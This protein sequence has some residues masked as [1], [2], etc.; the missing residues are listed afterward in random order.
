[1]PAFTVTAVIGNL[2]A[3]MERLRKMRRKIGPTVKKATTKGA[4]VLSKGQKVRAKESQESGL[5]WKSLGYVVRVYSGDGRVIAAV[6]PRTGMGATV[7]LLDGK[8]AIASS[9]AGQRLVAKGAK[10]ERRDPVRYA[11]L[12]ER[13]HGFMRAAQDEDGPAAVEDMRQVFLDEMEINR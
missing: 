5:L 6:G 2:S 12:A 10:T 7:A 13:V 1:M 9:K 11:H 4:Q 3:E 8:G